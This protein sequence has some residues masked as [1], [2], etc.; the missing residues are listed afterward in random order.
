MIV[1]I[2]Q[3]VGT[4]ATYEVAEVNGELK[5]VSIPQAVGTVATWS[6]FRSESFKVS[7]P[8]AVGTVATR[9]PLT[10]ATTADFMF[11]YRKR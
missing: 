3:A 4:V 6:V 1:S 7:I 10:P 5:A 9:T 8:Q 2:P 11:Q